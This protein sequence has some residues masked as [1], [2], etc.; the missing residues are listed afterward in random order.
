MKALVFVES[1]KGQVRESSL[2]AI[3]FARTL[4]ER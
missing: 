1:I 2:E 4:A 3:S